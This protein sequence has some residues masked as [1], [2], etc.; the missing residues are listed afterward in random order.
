MAVNKYKFV[1]STVNKQ[2]DIPIEIKW[3]F[4][5]RD[6][7]IDTYQSEVVDKLLGTAIDF[8]LSRFAHESYFNQEGLDSKTKINYEFYFFNTGF[9]VNNPNGW[10]NTYLVENFSPQDI[11]FFSKPFTKSFFKLDFYDTTNKSSQKNYFTIILPVQ[12]GE[13]ETV[14]ISSYLSNIQ[15][16]KPKFG[17][18]YIGDKE[19]F[20]IYWLRERDYINLDEFY[21]SA[22]F[23][24]ARLGVFVR[25]MNRPQSDFAQSNGFYNFNTQD[26]FF[27]KV[28]LDYATKTYQVF[29]LQ[30]NLRIGTDS[31]P[32][33]WYE[34]LNP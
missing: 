32:I 33:K 27:Q 10:E 1:K 4:S 5:E 26:Y 20:F 19:G 6:Q 34:F 13:T 17:L 14:T 2:V 25:M 7:A 12:Q 9:T 15:I 24:N 31:D 23:F 21:M 30:T 28:K 16:K 11:Y 29:D 3:D 22:K 8:E 18:D